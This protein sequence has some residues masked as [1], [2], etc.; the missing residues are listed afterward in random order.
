M[1][2]P[3]LSATAIGAHLVREIIAQVAGLVHLPADRDAVR[4]VQ[5][6]VDRA[7]TTLLAA[8]CPSDVE[9]ALLSIQLRQALADVSAIARRCSPA[10]PA[11]QPPRRAD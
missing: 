4:A 5:V 1:T 7:E 3:S 6:A 9:E 11:D 8:S 10:T 2:G